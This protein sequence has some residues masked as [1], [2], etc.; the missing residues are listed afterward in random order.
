ML[1]FFVGGLLGI[2]EWRAQKHDATADMSENSD[3]SE[4]EHVQF[5]LNTAKAVSVVIKTSE[6]SSVAMRYVGYGWLL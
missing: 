6:W 2:S 4:E 1:S 5:Q 3:M